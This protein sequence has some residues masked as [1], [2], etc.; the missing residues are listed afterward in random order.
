MKYVEQTLNTIKS[1]AFW[2]FIIIVGTYI[3]SGLMVLQNLGMP[4]TKT[5]TDMVRLPSAVIAI[6]YG[7]T[8][9]LVNAS[10]ENPLSRFTTIGIISAGAILAIGVIF[11]HFFLPIATP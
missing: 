10:A 11:V 3:V 6:A 1:V 5:L 9:L 2:F 8:A 4:L 7:T